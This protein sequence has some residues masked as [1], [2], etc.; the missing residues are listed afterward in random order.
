MTL[1]RA[2]LE[3]WWAFGL[4]AVSVSSLAFVNHSSPAR[5]ADG[6]GHVISLYTRVADAVG[7]ND[8]I[9]F[10][11]VAPEPAGAVAVFFLAQHALAPRIVTQDIAASKVVVSSPG[12]TS[13]LDG[14]P[15]LSGFSLQKVIEGGIRIYVRNGR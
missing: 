12:A 2:R 8:G 4:L 1:L 11:T 15:R 5:P 10:L 7:T 14:D 3:R 6:V 13:K 9:G